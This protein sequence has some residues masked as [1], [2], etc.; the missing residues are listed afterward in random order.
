MV[1]VVKLLFA[2]IVF[3]FAQPAT[4]QSVQIIP[5]PV[6]VKT[7]EGTFQ[8]SGETRLLLNDSGENPAAEFLNNY[9]QKYYGFKLLVAKEAKENFIRLN[10]LR[11]IK[12]PEKPEHYSLKVTPQSI[13]IEGD[14]Y[15]GTFYGMQSL[16]QLLPVTASK[17]MMLPGLLLDDYPRFGYRGMHLDVSRHFFDVSFIKTYIDYLALHKLNT[18]HWHLTDDQGWR[19]EIKKYPKLT[20]VGGYRNGTIIGRYPGKGNDSIHYGGYYTQ[21]EV[22]DV[23]KY[24]AD[25]YITVIP[26]IEMPGHA[27]A[28]IAA[29]PELSCFANEPT[30]PAKGTAWSGPKTGKQVQQAWGVFDDI[31]CA[32]NEQTFEMLTGV[33]DEVISLFPSQVIHVGGDEAPK[34][35]WKRCAKCQKRI[36]DERLKD[37]HELQSYF[38]QRIEK[39]VNS[40][41]RKIMGWDEILEGGLAPNAA[42]MSWRGEKGGIAAANQNHNVVMTPSSHLYFDFA[43]TRLEDSVT[44]GNYLPI[45]KVYA[46][47]PIPKELSANEAGF[48]LGGQANLWTEYMKNNK[49]VEYMALPRMSA[50]SEILWSPKDDRSFSEF[51]PRLLTQLKRYDLWGANYS[52]ALYEI[53][54]TITPAGDGVLWSLESKSPAPIFITHNA[55]NTGLK[56]N[57]PILINGSGELEATLVANN[58]VIY[59]LKH[60]FNINKATGKKIELT[61]PPSDY[62]PRQ[63]WCLWT[64]KRADLR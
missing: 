55:T 9:L 34:N 30:Q 11:F 1:R 61:T 38:V 19:I 13:S 32:G 8:L 3:L 17:S 23:V 33:L 57:Q 40:K 45:E 10:T 42:V 27:S 58:K 37:E 39:H 63:W 25:R 29:Y 4:S 60:N 24:A 54:S 48:I 36:K 18:F 22:R 64:C 7:G 51:E 41:G 46:Y 59:T 5:A 16:I 14:S 21:Q 43:Q 49:K 28:A 31:F 20:T 12:K 50:L 44:I 56:Y 35:N 6:N 2:W 47:D 53:K 26:E 15:A 52:K 62:V